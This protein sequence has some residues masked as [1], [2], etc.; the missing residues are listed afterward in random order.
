MNEG[1]VVVYIV[2]D[3]VVG[4]VL[5]VEFVLSKLKDKDKIKVVEL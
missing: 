1:K 5:V 4:G 3:N 2:L